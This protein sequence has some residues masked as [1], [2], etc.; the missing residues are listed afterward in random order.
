MDAVK[1]D[2]LEGL[3][4]N[5][6][7]EEE[8]VGMIATN[9]I[10]G[11]IAGEVVAGL[12]DPEVVGEVAGDAGHNTVP[13]DVGHNAVPGDAGQGD[14][15]TE[16]TDC[17]ALMPGMDEDAQALHD[18]SGE[19]EGHILRHALWVETWYIPRADCLARKQELTMRHNP[20]MSSRIYVVC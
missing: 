4:S 16:S 19:H 7:D 3:L 15:E 8:D 1:R 12:T 5:I 20:N 13:G 2:V 17:D 14:A 9:E 6:E 11:E 10:V 18:E